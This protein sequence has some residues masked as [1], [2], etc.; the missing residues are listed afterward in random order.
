MSYFYF[1][2]ERPK[3][4]AF[5]TKIKQGKIPQTSESETETVTAKSNAVS[6]ETS[7][8]AH[9]AAIISEKKA[10]SSMIWIVLTVSLGIVFAFIV[11]NYTIRRREQESDDSDEIECNET[12]NESY[13]R[14]G[15]NQQH[16]QMQRILRSFNRLGS[17]RH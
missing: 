5:L 11:I 7:K 6:D 14:F 9:S 17:W 3:A 12:S 13:T 4:V 15:S 8:N 1:F 10:Y 16:S 2:L